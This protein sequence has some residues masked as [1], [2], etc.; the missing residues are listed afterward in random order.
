MPV[1]HS[2][3]SNFIF[4]AAFLVS[5]TSFAGASMPAGPD[6][7]FLTGR[8]FILGSEPGPKASASLGSTDRPLRIGESSLT[9][10]T[11]AVV[12]W[13]GDQDHHRWSNPG[14]WDGGRV[15]GPTDVARFA[16]NSSSEVLVDAD[17]SGTVAGLILEPD[18]H[19]TLSLK[20]DLTVSNDLVLAGGTLNQGDYGLR[21]GN[22]RQTGGTFKG[23]DSSLMIQFDVI[24]SGGTL[25]TSK[26]M[27]ARSLTIT[28]PAVVTMAAN[29]KLNLTGDGQPLSGNGSL[30]V[31]TNGPNSIEYTGRA[32]ADVTAAG[33]IRG[34][35]GVVEPSQSDMAFRL[36]ESYGAPGFERP[37]L[38]QVHSQLRGLSRLEPSRALGGERLTRSPRPPFLPDLTP[39]DPTQALSGSFSRNAALTLTQSDVPNA[40]AIDTVNGFAYFGTSTAVGPGA[41]VKVRL[42]DFT[43]VGAL[44]LTGDDEAPGSAVID[45]AGG[46]VYFGGYNGD[47][48]KVRLSDFTLV[49][50]IETGT[51]FQSAALIDTNN[52]FAYFG[53]FTSP[54]GVVKVRLSDFTIVDVLVLN[55]DEV[56]I[57][58]G[59]IDTVNGFAY[60][61]TYN[62]NNANNPTF[63]VKVRL[64]D[65][66][67]VGNLQLPAFPNGTNPTCG[68][69]DMANGYAYFGLFESHNII[70]V[71]LSDFTV[72]D[73]LIPTTGGVQQLR[74][75]VIDTV[76]GYAYFGDT[77]GKIVKLR[78]SDFSVTEVLSIPVDDL[79]C[80]AIDT[81][82]GF[83]YFG[84]TA[85]QGVVKVRLSDFSWTYF[86]PFSFG[87]DN[88][89]AATIDADNGFAYF[90]TGL[91]PGVVKVRLSDFTRV[92]VLSFPWS[93][94]NSRVFSSVID[95]ANGYAYFGTEGLRGKIAKV[96]LSDFT[97]VS[98]LTLNSGEGN[99]SSAGIDPAAGFAYFGWNN[100]TGTGGLVKVRLSDLTRVG[101]VTLN[102]NERPRSMVIDPMNGFAY[103]GT[104]LGTVVKVR[105]KDLTRIGAV[106]L[107]N[108]IL[109]SA[110]A[111]T[112]A[113]F[114]YFGTVGSGVCRLRLSDFSNAFC[115]PT[116]SN[117][118][119]AA[120][121]TVNGFA[122][123]GTFTSPG[124]VVKVNLTNFGTITESLV[125]NVGEDHLISAVVDPAN[126]FAYF[127]TLTRPGIV[128]KIDLGYATPTNRSPFDIDGDGK[129]DIAI[130][131]PDGGEWWWNRSSDGVT[132]AAQFGLSTDVIAP[133]DF[134][135]DGKMD[136]AFFRPSDGFWNILRSED[137]TY[138]AFPFGT[139]GDVPVTGDYD[140]D[141]KADVAV[142]RPSNSTWYIARSTDSQISISQFG[143]AG[144]VPVTA[145][146]DGDGKDD[147][148]VMRP[149]GPNG[150]EWWIARSTDG[151][152]AMQF[153][154]STDRAV[155]A[156]YTG[157][158]KA[159]VAFWR[160]ATGEWYVVRSEDS[161][162]YAV[163]FGAS[164]DMPTPGDYDGD[165]KSDL[166]VFRPSQST[167]YINRST[168]GTQIASFGLPG[169]RPVPNSFVR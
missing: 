57:L 67:R 158:G 68:V 80:A 13:T 18:F 152:L 5:A 115:V 3:L 150:A 81:A 95:T 1:F 107:T 40:A 92:G 73:T 119:S 11:A 159:D 76:N 106:S 48:I 101:S 103:I 164:G 63:I 47:I 139:T 33:P 128:V 56:G 131:R 46:F 144:D 86:T 20:R 50:V 49:A 70:K 123:F 147:I 38:P 127:G 112:S 22:Y 130:F 43:R 58:S 21:L 75:A 124:S 34:A 51:G 42:S 15:P 148:G 137:S 26:S 24:V 62:N 16:A 9:I 84:G 85:P 142:F 156:D 96:R 69:I 113:G 136:I 167:W 65:F 55:T 166:A 45:P 134:T 10:K 37:I 138:Y 64:S 31:R 66:T 23:G 165:G 100:N 110:V 89:A 120:I 121:D 12:T 52:G 163:P 143:I 72:A 29:S 61:G 93:W 91:A 41:I 146:Y 88:L 14:N 6:P 126:G 60:F 153:G 116:L 111:D 79:F 135:G 54:G 78:L 94:V 28:A 149:N 71:R 117:L 35:L 30:D 118:Q 83:A 168:A 39:A 99:L 90:A 4:I 27:T 122:Y 109:L 108:Q 160:P 129:T 8:G 114:A 2:Q 82:G 19:G 44:V 155:P 36:R 97:L 151:L 161:T 162:Y 157:D 53:S 104:F 102:T 59:V 17:S 32:T 140:G 145:D 154:S 74:S 7:N 125:L 98:T 87:E 105:L 133:G 132:Q 141:G 25:L 169:D 77:V